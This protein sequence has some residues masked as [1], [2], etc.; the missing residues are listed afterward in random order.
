MKFEVQIHR[1]NRRKTASIKVLQGVVQ[2]VVPKTLPQK[3]IDDLLKQKSDWI[4]Q[5]VIIQQSVP[6]SKPKELSPVNPSLIWDAT[7][8]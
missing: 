3:E 6:A 1:T 5:K 2:V 7:T 4:R 8:D